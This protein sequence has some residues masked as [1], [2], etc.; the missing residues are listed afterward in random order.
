M[1]RARHRAP[2]QSVCEP[3]H[4][5]PKEPEL[6]PPEFNGPFRFLDLPC[7]VRC[8]VYG[9]LLLDP[10]DGI[11]PQYKGAIREYVLRP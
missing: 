4:P 8:H 11:Q 1:P 10:I 3:S 5:S 6:D 7:E 2:H 9:H